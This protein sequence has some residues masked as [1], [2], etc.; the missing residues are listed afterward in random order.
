MKEYS[1]FSW[2]SQSNMSVCWFVCLSVSLCVSPFLE[3]DW[4]YFSKNLRMDFWGIAEVIATIEK[5]APVGLFLPI[6]WGV[7]FFTFLFFLRTVKHF[8]LLKFCKNFLGNTLIVTTQKCYSM[9]LSAGVHLGVIWGSFW[10]AFL[11][12]LRT[13]QYWILALNC[14][15][16]G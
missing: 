5:F 12:F 1:N 6:F 9:A 15:N 11:S 10:C 2:T 4:I 16:L 14:F 13:V 8:L 3:N 7:F